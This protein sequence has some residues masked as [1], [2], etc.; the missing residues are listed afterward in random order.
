MT[1]KYQYYKNERIT[2]SIFIHIR[3]LSIYKHFIFQGKNSIF[4]VT[5][6]F[7]NM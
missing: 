3:N 5:S 2:Y 6:N 7:S 4:L 1:K